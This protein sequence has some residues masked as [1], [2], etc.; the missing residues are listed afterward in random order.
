MPIFVALFAFCLLL[1]CGTT[2]EE[3]VL[4]DQPKA[5]GEYFEYINQGDAAFL[6]KHLPE[7]N[8]EA[9]KAYE[10]AFSLKKDEPEL[11][12]KLMR[13]HYYAA[14]YHGEQLKKEEKL[15]LLGTARNYG[16]EGIKLNPQMKAAIEANKDWTEVASLARR[17]DVAIMYW[18]SICWGRWG[19]MKG[20]TTVAADIGKVRAL[21]DKVLELDDIYSG[22]GADRFFGVFFMEIPKINGRD[23]KKARE[24]FEKAIALTPDFLQNYILFAEYYAVPEEDEDLFVELCEKIL[25]KEKDAEN[26]DRDWKIDNDDAIRKAKLWLTEDYRD[27]VF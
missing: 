26:M 11:Y 7:K 20:I 9:L 17:S 19:E 6:D 21:M 10:N 12:V 24:H 5:S 23:P 18:L 22:G 16:L 14:M 27:E 3:V 8:Q 2:T 15:R 25:E 13:A 4:P 1:S